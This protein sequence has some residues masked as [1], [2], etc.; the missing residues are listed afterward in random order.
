MN[1][2]GFPVAHHWVESRRD[3]PHHH[4][5]VWRPGWRTRWNVRHPWTSL[6]PIAR[7]YLIVTLHP[8]LSISKAAASAEGRTSMTCCT[9]VCSSFT[10]AD[11]FCGMTSRATQDNKR[12]FNGS[13][14]RSSSSAISRNDIEI[15]GGCLS[16]GPLSR[17]RV[18]CRLRAM[19]RLA[20]KRES[21]ML[22]LG[23]P[24]AAWSAG[25][26]LTVRRGCSW[27]A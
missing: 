22:S 8:V 11:V 26:P 21:Q 14:G 13:S 12:S 27:L 4:I 25:C 19:H 18:G 23:A 6:P 1:T 3:Q 24:S 5:A 2:L 7:T 15:G 16:C 9:D 10:T 20:L 17:L